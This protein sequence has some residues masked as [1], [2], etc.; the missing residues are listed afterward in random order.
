MLRLLPSDG[1]QDL[2]ILPLA[3]S[4]LAVLLGYYFGR[5]LPL[6]RYVGGLLTGSAMLLVPAMLARDDLKQ[7]T[8]EACASIA[9]L[10][11]VA[12]IENNWTR[13]RLVGIAVLTVGGLLFAN[14]VIF[15]G[16]A[17]MIALVISTLVQRD[18]HRTRESAVALAGTVTLS[19][20]LFELIDARHVIPSETQ[21]WAFFYVP[22]SQGLS[23][24]WSFVYRLSEGLAPYL[25]SRFLWLDAGLALLGI[26]G[27]VWVKRYAL[28]AVVPITIVVVIAASADRR[29]PYGDARTSTFWLVMVAL[30][31]AIG[32]GFVI[33]ILAR[34]NYAWALVAAVLSIAIY[35]VVVNPYIRSHALVN[36]DV[37]SQVSYVDSHR[38]P[39]DVVIVNDGAA[40]GFAYYERALTPSFSHVSFA[41]TGFLPTFPGVPWLIVMPRESDVQAALASAVDQIRVHAN[42][43]SDRVWIIR[44]HDLNSAAWNQALSGK[45]VTTIP[46]GPEPLLL[47]R[48]S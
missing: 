15:V 7:Y 42:S 12:R 48:P 24:A 35:A 20:L 34:G 5:E 17:A 27:L 47:Y 26:A 1:G 9:I 23:V 25:G 14:T 29:Y 4:A 41:A 36:E 40:Y 8:A 38:R 10:L 2:R 30:L 33:S 44:S 21:Y 28:A 31:M 46:V 11:L 16:I 37:R 43:G 32:V 13:G 6:P 45:Q 22:R 3:F 18:Y 39:G 19:A